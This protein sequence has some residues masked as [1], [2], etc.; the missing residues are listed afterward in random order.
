MQT[1]QA[2]P[3]VSVYSVTLQD[4]QEQIFLLREAGSGTRI[5]MERFFAE[6]GVTL[7]GAMEMNSNEAIKQG[8]E[9]GLGL[10]VLSI[11]TV[12]RELEHGQLVTLDVELFPINRQW[13]LVHRRG[14]RL[15]AI[16]QTFKD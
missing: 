1:V 11:H 3:T 12:E 14:K 7:S 16:A 10:A 6:H 15:N 8:V 5:A 13:F 2:S 4:I 9:A